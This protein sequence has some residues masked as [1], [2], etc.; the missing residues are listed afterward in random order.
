M[1]SKKK[2]LYRE[3]T[4]NIHNS[5]HVIDSRKLGVGDCTCKYTF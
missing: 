1:S 5:N 2:Y 3:H 4:K